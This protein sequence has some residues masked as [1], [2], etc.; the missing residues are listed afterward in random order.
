MLQPARSDTSS[1]FLRELEYALILIEDSKN[2]KYFLDKAK[3]VFKKR[4]D[5]NS[6]KT[7]EK[8]LKSEIL[9]Y[10]RQSGYVKT[11]N[12]W[13]R[14]IA[15]EENAINDL[16]KKLQ[17]TLLANSCQGILEIHLQDREINSP[18]IQYVGT[19]SELAESIIAKIVVDSKY[20][21]SLE[22]A[23][24]K[25]DFKP[26]YLE[27]ESAEQP[28]NLDDKIE[29]AKTKDKKE[30]ESTLNYF[31]KAIERIKKSYKENKE[32]L[33]NEVL[34]PFDFIKDEMRR[35]IQR[36][37]RKIRLRRR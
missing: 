2:R 6:T 26:F 17:D 8:E 16:L 36:Q 4:I 33:V 19:N 23:I 30:L 24:G 7:G 12:V 22:S 28:K 18:H 1:S 3:E 25:K 9:L 15:I 31:S 34:Q 11:A 21:I 35:K 10:L 29:E 32:R 20:E 13:A 27:N 37:R 5:V 14:N